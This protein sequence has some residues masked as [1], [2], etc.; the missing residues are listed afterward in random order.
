MAKVISSMELQKQTRGELSS[1]PTCAPVLKVG[2]T[3]A[4]LAGCEMIGA[5]HLAKAL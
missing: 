2:R 5:T 3:I 1:I 4:D